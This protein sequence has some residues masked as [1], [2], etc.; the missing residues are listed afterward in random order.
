MFTAFL[1]PKRQKKK[2]RQPEQ[3]IVTYENKPVPKKSE[4]RDSHNAMNTP[5][6]HVTPCILV[7]SY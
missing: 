3:E 7:G 6:L 4:I 1:R 2:K 5:L